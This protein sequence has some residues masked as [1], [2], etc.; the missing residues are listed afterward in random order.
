MYKFT[1]IS[2]AFFLVVLRR[3]YYLVFSL[4]DGFR[5]TMLLTGFQSHD[6]EKNEMLQGSYM[7]IDYLE[8]L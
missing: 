1:N 5:I 7:D 2:L 4:Y 6:Q 8:Y 3:L